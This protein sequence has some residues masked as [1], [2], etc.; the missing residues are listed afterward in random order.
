MAEELPRG[1]VKSMDRRL[2]WRRYGR[3][4]ALGQSGFPFAIGPFPTPVSHFR[5][6][7]RR[8]RFARRA[9]GLAARLV[10]M[11][12][13]PFG[14]FFA[15][16]RSWSRLREKG[17][18]PQGPRSLL[19]MY[20]LALRHSIPP[21]DYALYRLSDP[22]HRRDLHHFVCSNDLPGLAVLA[23][24]AGADH[25]DVQDKDRFAQICSAHGL[26]HVETLAAFQA[27][28]QTRP[29]QP[30]VPELPVLWTKARHLKGGAGGAAWTRDGAVYRD[31]AGRRLSPAELAVSLHQWDCIV[32]PYIGNHPAMTGLSNGALA[33]L[34]VVTGM[35]E[36]GE[37]EFVTSL[38]ALPHGAKTTSVAGILC[39]IEPDSGHIRRAMMPDGEQVARH[40]DSGEPVVGVALPF[41]FESVALARRAHAGAFPRFPFLGW[42]IALTADGP[43]LLEA[44]M[45]WGAIF[46]QMLDGPLGH[47]VFSRLV[48][49]HL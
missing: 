13:W 39:S 11:L 7:A 10:M 23:A 44:N 17:G 38:L 14:A 4:I 3:W 32:Q 41:W 45:C 33:A 31:A 2:Y 18:P 42:D 5:A 35:N 47:T 22:A 24:R 15:A 9:G 16:L 25:R 6:M 19:D 46:H 28:R 21:T 49:R 36:R 43:L 29:V 20:W 37:G 34:R 48:A 40:P 8:T 12:A 1:A 30:F 27:G 26:P